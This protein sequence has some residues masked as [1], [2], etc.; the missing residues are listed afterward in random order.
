MAK[1]V[2]DVEKGIMAVGGEL[3]LTKKLSYLNEIHLKRAC[4][5]S[6]VIQI[7][8]FPRWSSL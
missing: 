5:A 4:E 3:Q 7:A 8:I 6:T 2:V 1:A